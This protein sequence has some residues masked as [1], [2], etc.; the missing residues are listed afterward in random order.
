MK[1]EVLTLTYQERLDVTP[2]DVAFLKPLMASFQKLKR[3]LW[4]TLYGRPPAGRPADLTEFKRAFCAKHQISSTAY[5]SIKNEVD[6]L[7]KAQR[8]LLET[9]LIEMDAKRKSVAE[10][11]A[12]NQ[13][14]VAKSL[15]KMNALHEEHQARL[16][17]KVAMTRKKLHH[18]ARKLAALQRKLDKIKGQMDLGSNWSPQVAFGGKA[19]QN[20]QHDL[21]ANGYANHEQWLADWQF[22]RAS[23]VFFLGDQ[24]EKSRNREVKGTEALAVDLSADTLRLRLTIP[25]HLR[26]QFDGQANYSLSPIKLSLRTLAALRE[27]LGTTYLKEVKK[28]GQITFK[29]MHLP[30]SWRIVRRLKTKSLKDG[31]KVTA[32]VYYLQCITQKRIES[33]Q[34]CS[35]A[36]AIGVDQNLDHIAVGIIDRCGNPRDSFTIPF[37][38]SENDAQQNRALIGA[39]AADIATLA[40]HLGV[41]I[42]SEKLDF[43]R[44]KAALKESYGPKVNHRFSA[45]S[46]AGVA[47]GIKTAALKRSVQYIEINPA[48][49]SLISAVNYF[50][51]RD[52]ISS[53][54]AACFTIARRGLHFADFLDFSA[55]KSQKTPSA[56]DEKPLPGRTELDAYMAS[57]P[58]GKRGHL[59]GFVA[60]KDVRSRFK[61]LMEFYSGG[62]SW[63][64]RRAILGDLA[65]PKRAA[66][67]YE[68]LPSTA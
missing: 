32:E 15:A 18:K 27:A 13:A 55:I 54:E 35:D 10:W 44:K 39:I 4:Q 24:G 9:R 11:L 58:T 5:N 6:G 30:L 2:D 40:E 3:T 20:A 60:Q 52:H 43:K 67:N 33:F 22:A 57:R 49:S 23:A 59:W 8:E 7:F 46:Y 29:E 21:E 25:E 62:N 31:T 64:G 26:S 12:S 50:G 19:L 41:P 61:S 28:N 68:A 45:F 65:S 48:Y 63:L 17:L 37:R 38:P 16:L 14:M 36:G 1:A 47:N 56:Q 51:M 66:L 42:V 34:S 53:H